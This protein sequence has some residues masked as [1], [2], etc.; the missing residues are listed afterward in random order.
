MYNHVNTKGII[1]SNELKH[2]EEEFRQAL[3]DRFEGGAGD[4]SL[5]RE[6]GYTPLAAFISLTTSDNEIR[7][8]F[9]YMIHSAGMTGQQ[10]S[11]LEDLGLDPFSSVSY[12]SRNLEEFLNIL[13]VM[14]EKTPPN[15]SLIHI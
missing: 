10:K 11:L 13:H 1:V 2:I 14:W 15:L 6:S 4:Y 8:S 5:L 12:T 9:G 7:P 3:D